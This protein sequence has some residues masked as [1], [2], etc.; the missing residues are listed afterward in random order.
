MKTFFVSLGSGVYGQLNEKLVQLQNE[1]SSNDFDFFNFPGLSP[2]VQNAIREMISDQK[3][4][5]DANKQKIDKIS[6]GLDGQDGQS[7]DLI[8]VFTVPKF[9]CLYLSFSRIAWKSYL[10]FYFNRVKNKTIWIPRI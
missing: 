7:R 5:F 3:D 2:L 8:Q 10:P 4:D 6:T 9:S 1:Y